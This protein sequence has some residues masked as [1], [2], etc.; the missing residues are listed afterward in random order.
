[1]PPVADTSA[2]NGYAPITA[3]EINAIIR[4]WLQFV[5]LAQ[6][7]SPGWT[8]EIIRVRYRKKAGLIDDGAFR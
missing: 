4:C 2:N 6:I 7:C 8:I 3:V 1:M 5:A